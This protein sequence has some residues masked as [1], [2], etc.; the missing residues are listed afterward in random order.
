MMTNC[1]ADWLGSYRE[2]WLADFEFRQP[3]GGLPEPHCMVAME[4]ITERVL[5]FWI[6][7]LRSMSS[8]PFPTGADTLFVAYL[9]SAEL[10]VFRQLG[11]SMPQRMIDLYAEFRNFTNGKYL[12]HGRSLLGALLYFGLPGIEAV[13]KENMRQLAIRGGPFTEQEKAD[14]LVY[15]ES[16]VIALQQLLPV[17]QSY[18]E[19][20]ALLRGRYMSAVSAM[21]TTGTPI[22][23]ITFRRLMTHW[24]SIKRRI[25]K[26]IDSRY[27]IYDGLT[28]KMDRF[29]EWLIR[30]GI[31]WSRLDS[32]RLATDDDTFK[33]MSKI[34]PEVSPIHELRRMF[35]T[36]KTLRLSVGADGR[37]RCMLSPF[38][39]KTGRNQPSTTRFIFG[40]STWLRGLIKPTEG[41]AV[42]YIDYSQQEFAI[43]AVLSRDEAMMDAYRSGDPY[44]AFAKQAAAVPPDATK[45]SHKHIRDQFKL[46]ALGVQYGLSDFGLAKQLGKPGIV[47][48]QLLQSHKETYPKFWQWSEETINRGLLGFSLSTTFGWRHHF[49]PRVSQN[50]RSLSNFPVQATGAEILRLACSLATERGVMVCAPVHDAVLIEGSAESIDDIVAMTQECFV[51]ASR[52]VLDGFEL[53]S[54]AKIVR[55]PDRYMDDRGIEMWETVMRILDEIESDEGLLK[56]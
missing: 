2:I 38:Q 55:Y 31:P 32:G 3:E 24:E 18:L 46:C 25:V 16:D 8:P 30:K 56:G 42:A 41:Q 53:R 11:W 28:F 10:N 17:M 29:E 22:D 19:P 34:F 48:R 39:S 40:P 35:S 26:R 37:N 21:E 47:G 14:L 45:E 13:E 5:C 51:E 9:N 7:D 49:D 50:P 27:G 33:Q 15:C 12:P 6:D 1:Q 44:L 4:Y 23:M 20:Q 43:A 54:D 36:L 52:I